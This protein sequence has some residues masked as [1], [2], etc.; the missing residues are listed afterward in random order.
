MKKIIPMIAL[1]SIGVF[2]GLAAF[3]YYIGEITKA[4]FWMLSAIALI[5]IVTTTNPDDQ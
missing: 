4:I 1:M 2:Y 5:I 3:S